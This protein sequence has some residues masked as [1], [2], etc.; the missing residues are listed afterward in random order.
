V[1]RQTV[2]GIQEARVSVWAEELRN[3]GQVYKYPGPERDRDIA[4]ML[5]GKMQF[6]TAYVPMPL[7]GSGRRMD[8]TLDG[9]PSLPA[10]TVTMHF[11]HGTETK[12][13]LW[14]GGDWPRGQLRHFDTGSGFLAWDPESVDVEIGFADSAYVWRDTVK[15]NT[16]GAGGAAS[17]LR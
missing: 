1:G 4:A 16:R 12:T 5:E 6:R 3:E 15:I 11:R 14:P 8:L 13:K 17:R 10:H 9:V 7:F 2:Y